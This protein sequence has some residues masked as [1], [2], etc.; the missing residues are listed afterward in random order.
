MGTT[1]YLFDQESHYSTMFDQM[2]EEGRSYALPIN[3]LIY[4]GFSLDPWDFE[5][6]PGYLGD[7]GL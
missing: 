2:S 5:L 3:G 1:I 7:D 4:R 6:E